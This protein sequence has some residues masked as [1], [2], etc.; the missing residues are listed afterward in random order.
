MSKKKTYHLIRTRN[1]ETVERE[2]A[3]KRETAQYGCFFYL[4][5]NGYANKKTATLVATKLQN[6]AVSEHDGIT[7]EMV[8]R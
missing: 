1:G 6:T 2:Y 4:L 7:F 8:V 5:D 3:S